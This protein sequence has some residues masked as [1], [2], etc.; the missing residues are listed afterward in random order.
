[1]AIDPIE[2]PVDVDVGGLGRAFKDAADKLRGF[3]K[4]ADRPRDALGRFTSTGRKTTTTLGEIGSAA[5][6]AT[7]VLGGLTRA[8]SS[9]AS[10]AARSATAIGSALLELAERGGKISAISKSFESLADQAGLSSSRILE[11][12]G[13]ATSGLVSQNELMAASNRALAAQLPISEERFGSLA[14]AAIKLGSALGVGASDAVQRLTE[15]LAKQEP[16][17]LDELGIRVDLTAALRAEAASRGVAA[18][19][20]DAQTR[21]VTFLNA[22]EKQAL[23]RSAALGDEVLPSL[24]LSLGRASVAA[25]DTVDSFSRLVTENESLAKVVD[26]LAK[27]IG[28]AGDFLKANESR[29]SGFFDLLS[30]K[31]L[32]A[33]S[34]FGSFESSLRKGLEFV[35]ASLKDNSAIVSLFFTAARIGVNSLQAAVGGVTTLILEVGFQLSGLLTSSFKLAESAAGVV[36]TVGL[37]VS[38]IPGFSAQ[39]KKIQEFAKL[40]KG[41]FGLA[42]VEVEKY[43]GKIE[44]AS[45]SAQKFFNNGLDG[46][47][48]SV[49][50][51]DSLADSI[52]RAGSSLESF[53]S[54]LNG[55]GSG[56]I[57]GGVGSFLTSAARGAVGLAN[58]GPGVNAFNA[59]GFDGT[60]NPAF[61][62]FESF[63][64]EREKIE[65]EANEKLLK[66]QEKARK[67]AVRED[68]RELNKALRRQEREAKKREK[69]QER[70]IQKAIKAEEKRQRQL[71]RVTSRGTRSIVQ[72]FSNGLVRLGQ[73]VTAAVQTFS[74]AG[75]NILTAA[76]AG[77]TPGLTREFSGPLGARAALESQRVSDRFLQGQFGFSSG[78][79]GLPSGDTAIR[80]LGFNKGG[81]VPGFGSQ[82]SVLAALTP[83]ERVLRKGETGE[84]NVTTGP[85][86]IQG[87]GNG[88][89]RDFVDGIIREI[90]RRKSLGQM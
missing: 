16:E 88:A 63:Y 87:S 75:V 18:T 43:R 13:K 90:K 36:E 53:A 35:G 7:I 1:M 34:R 71:Q 50:Q 66:A 31:A 69:Q 3:G 2:I 38:L 46:I 58:S 57:F 27:G 83:G 65:R 62:G 25:E 70:A 76:Q 64:A 55:G 72:T 12:L 61:A 52:S 30:S 47:G 59:N 48:E 77:I 89:A 17:L 19:A 51:F 10:I 45:I 67:I 14:N 24:S 56:G 33:S 49:E 68:A 42:S 37:A 86:T 28:Q 8:L 44:E 26:L 20:L 81:D 85:I 39:G 41:A 60:Q 32:E 73:N 80:I 78:S 84:V 11:E 15:G 21:L 9:A 23:E 54:T 5:G 79:F 74:Q 4:A 82:D 40:A 29:I 22:V 6:G